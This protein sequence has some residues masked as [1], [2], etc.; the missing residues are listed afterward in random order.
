MVVK[1]SRSFEKERPHLVITDWNMPTVDGLSLIEAFKRNGVDVPIG[2][3]TGNGSKA[4]VE[5][6]Q[7]AGAAFVVTKPFVPDDL[8]GA[9]TPFMAS[10]E[11]FPTPNISD[12]NDGHGPSSSIIAALQVA[13][14]TE[15]IR[16]QAKAVTSTVQRGVFLRFAM[17]RRESWLCL[18]LIGL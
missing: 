9:L 10:L 8:K 12:P 1:G 14:S 7:A 13:V 15:S 11:G 4:E 5:R 3:V 6:A 16:P 18:H 2:M 17:K